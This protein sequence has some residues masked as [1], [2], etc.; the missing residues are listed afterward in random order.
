MLKWLRSV[1]AAAIACLCFMVMVAGCA[2]QM[3][4]Y[5]SVIA[6][7][8]E[9]REL[10]NK[11]HA[12][13]WPEIVSKLQECNIHNY[14]IYEAQLEKGRLFGFLGIPTFLTG[15]GTMSSGKNVAQRTTTAGAGVAWGGPLSAVR[16]ED[17]RLVQADN[18]DVV[19]RSF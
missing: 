6:L 14:S 8:S 15:N 1:N 4:R 18:L 12:A 13:P 5:G 11:L 7:K 3:Q 17:G 2:T 10:Y 16:L 19:A 9:K